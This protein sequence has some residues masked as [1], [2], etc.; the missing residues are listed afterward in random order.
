[1]NKNGIWNRILAVCLTIMILL[2]MTPANHAPYVRAE[3]EELVHEVRFEVKDGDN[4]IKGA[5]VKVSALDEEFE[6]ETDE[7]GI[8][9]FNQFSERLESELIKVNYKVIAEGYAQVEGEVE[10]SKDNNIVPIFMMVE[11]IVLTGIV[12]DEDDRALSEVLISASASNDD[13]LQTETNYNG[14]YELYLQSGVTYNISF[15]KAEYKSVSID[16]Y[17]P[18]STEPL[19]IKLSSKVYD[20]GFRFVSPETDT[21]NYQPNLEIPLR[22]EASTDGIDISYSIDW[23]NSDP[24]IASI[25]EISGNLII[26]KAGRVTVMA[27]RE[28]CDNYKETTISH[29]LTINKAQRS[30]FRFQYMGD[31]FNPIQVTITSGEYINQ[32]TDDQGNQ[33]VTYEIVEGNQY[34]NVNNQGVLTLNKAGTVIVKATIPE[35]DKYKQAEAYYYLNIVRANQGEFYFKFPQHTIIYS[36]GLKFENI[37]TGGS[38]TGAITYEI[39]EQHP[40]GHDYDVAMIED[41]S[42]GTLTILNVGWVKVR[43]TKEADFQYEQVTAEYTLVINKAEQT[44]FGFTNANEFITYNDNDN[45]FEN[46]AQGGSETGVITYKI[47]EGDA[48]I[49]EDESKGSLTILKAGRVKVRAIKTD[50]NYKPATAEYILTIDKAEQTGF[51]FEKAEEFMT[52]NENANIFENV[53]TGGESTGD[54]SYSIIRE[55]SDKG[56]ATI[57]EETGKLTIQ[58]AG[59]VVVMA[60]KTG[61]ECYKDAVASY[62]L[63]IEKA[64]QKIEFDRSEPDSIYLGEYFKNTAKAVLVEDAADGLGYGNGAITYS[65]VN[66]GNRIASVNEEG[67]ISYTY[68]DIGQITIKAVKEACS[69][70]KEATAEYILDIE[71]Q[72][73]PEVP[74]IIKGEAKNDSGWYIGDI[75]VYPTE[76]YLISESLDDNMRWVDSIKISGEGENSLSFFL[77]CQ[78]NNGITDVI[79]ID[80]SELLIDKSP[81]YALTIEY[82]KSWF[83]R[84][85]ET[86]FSFY[87]APMTVTLSATD[88][89]SAIQSF[90]YSFARSDGEANYTIVDISEMEVDGHTASYSFRVEPEF[91]GMVSFKAID[92][93]GNEQIKHGDKVI[94]VDTIAPKASISYSGPLVKMVDKNNQTLVSPDEDT[95]FIYNDNIEA[96]I[97]IREVNFYPDDVNIIIKRDGQVVGDSIFGG[98]QNIE[99]EDD[100]YV[101]TVT[102]SKDGD[103]QIFIEYQDSSGNE[104]EWESGEYTGKGGSKVYS[105]NI[106]TIDKT[107]P[108]ISVVFD[109]NTTKSYQGYFDADRIATIT[110][111]DRNFRADE[112]NIAVAASD[113]EGNQIGFDISDK[114]SNWQEI[115][116]YVWE[117]DLVFDVDASFTFNIE[118]IDMAGNTAD[119]ITIEDFVIDKSAP[120]NLTITYSESHS[121]WEDV[122]SAITFGYY[123]PYVKVTITAEDINAGIDYFNWTYTKQDGTSAV[124]KVEETGQI[125]AQ[126]IVYSN[127]GKTALASFTL[128][129]EQAAQYRG[130]I[131]F[132]ATDKAGNTSTA[133]RDDGCIVVVD[134]IAPTRTVEY[135]PAKQVLD[136]ATMK[137]KDRYSYTAEGTNSILYYDGP[138]TVTFRVKEANFYGEDFIVK[139]N[140]KITTVANWEK[141]ADGDEWTGS[142]RLST[143]GEYIVTAVYTDR[144]S[145]EMKS[146]RSEQIIIDTVKPVINV[147][148]SPSKGIRSIG[149]RTYYDKQQTA[150]IT[151]TEKNF[152]AN[153]VLVELTAKDISGNNVSISNYAAYLRDKNNWSKSGDKYTAVITY[154]VDANYT[155]DISYRDLALNQAAGY[156]R[157]EFTIDTKAPQNLSVSYSRSVLDTVLGGVSFGYYNAPITVTISAEDI[158]SGIQGFRYS[159]KNSSGVSKVNG[160]IIDKAIA[161]SAIKYSDDGK[162]AS[163][164][165]QI[166]ESALRANNQFNGTLEF[167]AIDRSDNSTDFIGK[168][169]LVVDNIT[170]TA[171]VSYNSPVQKLNDLSYY[172]GAI[173][174]TITIN[175]ANFFSDDVKVMV[176]KDGASPYQ[177]KPTWLDES[178]DIHTGSFTIEEDGSYFVTINY[179]DRS[180]N[181]MTEYV[182]N[183]LIIDT[184]KPSISVNGIKD[185]SANRGDTVGFVVTVEDQNLDGASFTPSLI[186]TIRNE[187]GNFETVDITQEGTINTIVDGK[188]YTYIVDNLELDGIYTLTCQVYDKARNLCNELMIIDSDLVSQDLCFSINRMGSSYALDSRVKE[189]NGSFVV[190]SEDIVITEVNADRLE[191]LKITLFKN[192][193]TITLVEGTDYRVDISRG[194]G[195][196]YQYSYTILGKNFAEDGVYRIAVY[197]ED[198][199]GNVSQ[200][201]LD[202]KAMDISFGVDKTS[203]NIIVTNLEK[204]VT[205]P[206]DF[207][208]VLMSVNDNLKLENVV[209]YL[210]DVEHMN[211]KAED[212]EKIIA[213]K[214]D[215]TF[216]IGGD[217]TRPHS[218]KIVATDA[219]GNKAI[220]EI[221]GFYV[222]KDLWV[223]YYN[224]KYLFF[225]SIAGALL[226]IVALTVLVLKGRK[227]KGASA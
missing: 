6:A 207:L 162:K 137:T 41:T 15:E 181:K 16:G 120:E 153:D 97:E 12:T 135:S 11:T 205:Y 224:N 106:M 102:L 142:I 144:S 8:A 61:D 141:A 177:V 82:S 196:W 183:K 69:K 63:S 25:D 173:K 192:N 88:D 40:H 62:S 21:L 35:D 212:I 169:R 184:T 130:N 150:V 148:Y 3:G 101:Q 165:F 73:T 91:E 189:I 202:T 86:V 5:L 7:N 157:D 216:D 154:S 72:P 78:D 50:H 66:S 28:G 17:M 208:T 56:V 175:E 119:E 92:V 227:K 48:A 23:H 112:L 46:V 180:G 111:E 209:V 14:E 182:S 32:A 201:T 43:A 36:E 152:R 222:T 70:Y 96:T 131:S 10:V 103:Y 109:N 176:S 81:P 191:G 220:S 187:N 199:A 218:V 217:S 166:P 171:S 174:A 225:G 128:T 160:Q 122:L 161:N 179:T 167:T 52:Y 9:V 147:K 95:R 107:K 203:P 65:V 75:F 126:D 44:G 188:K 105:S 20:E 156:A 94:V 13:I 58:M 76:G 151:I 29:T 197:T 200:N 45:I 132:T 121:L 64:E 139:V 206:L 84:F 2:G 60:K 149:G 80:N 116:P 186:A 34:A 204:G 133:L 127:N 140:D 87:N 124:N 104:F 100:A 113:I 168:R 31:E 226:L 71:Y 146:Y 123:K 93:A 155:F 138:M 114:I 26:N 54:I 55:K 59:K 89:I 90:A 24:G 211:W 85:L 129:A 198:A 210:N 57:D 39:V 213:E 178:I 118:Y 136:K 27:T 221:N 77:K 185:E 117:A 194:D 74:Y 68:K 79:Q 145:N 98:W 1:M 99:D 195:G 170:P 214:R 47:V 158:T 163:V 49:I 159:Y 51:G 223:R 53:A 108:L 83:D 18:G 143:D 134:T 22:A 38:G 19:D 33:A 172:S 193:Q 37:A 115:S 125:N 30:N 215:F 42:S 164:M 190:N 67:E 219:A 4:L 110:I